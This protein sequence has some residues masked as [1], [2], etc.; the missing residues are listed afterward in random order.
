MKRLP[1]PISAHGGIVNKVITFKTS[2]FD[3]SQEDENPINPIYGQSLL[4]W[5]KERISK[6]V[7]LTNPDAEDWG[8]YST[9]NWDERNYLVGAIAY[10]EEGDDPKD[11]IEW[12]L[13][14]DK[15]RTFKEKLLGQEKLTIKDSLFQLIKKTLD[16]EPNFTG[17]CV[18]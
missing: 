13:Q 6:V 14:I 16:E 8:W 3:V 4:H 12:I 7:L 5:L 18:E 9:L 15:S 1:I 17:V 10:F 11:E 2:M